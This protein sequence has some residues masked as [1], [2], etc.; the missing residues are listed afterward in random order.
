MLEEI[1]YDA[2]YYVIWA[3]EI[4]G[5]GIIVFGTFY[6]LFKLFLNKYKSIKNKDGNGS[7]VKLV[8][9]NYLALALEFMLAAEILRTVTINR[10]W[11]EIIVLGAIIILRATMSLLVSWEL[12]Y[13]DKKEAFIEKKRNRNNVK[14]L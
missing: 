12:S 9:A 5:I 6:S 1:V 4:I 3:I 13:E 11:S 14:P 2:L 7:S 8:L 10:E